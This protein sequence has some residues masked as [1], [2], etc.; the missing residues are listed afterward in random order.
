VAPSAAD[1]PGTSPSPPPVELR[2]ATEALAIATP[3]LARRPVLVASDFDGTLA[4][5]VLDPWGARIVP[6]A[7]RALR[8]LATLPGVHVAFV[9][10]RT[11][12][13]L[14]G[15]VRVGGATYVGDHGVERAR[16]ARHAR[17]EH[18]QADVLPHPAALG[19]LVEHVVG[20]VARAV[21][22][23][24]LVVERKRPGVTFH[25]RSA[26]DV[27]AAAGRVTAAVDRAD[28]GGALVRLAGRR[29]IELRAPGSPLKGEAMRALLDEHRPLVAFMLGDDRH[30]ARAFDV[31][32]AARAA[33]ELDGL[34]IA[35][36]AHPDSLADV[37]AHADLVLRSPRDAAGFLAGLARAL[38][39]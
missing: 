22:E 18:L 7:R 36:A 21:P 39:P 15:R 10:G 28:P 38:R 1:H 33:G 5:L 25:F 30:D 34:A 35:V 19:P 17:A 12:A 32:R 11:A 14:A 27:G 29:A 13:D 31:V 6:A 4:H 2:S 24:W 23:P 20:E 8:V 9:S 16:L 3:L 37:S 26:P